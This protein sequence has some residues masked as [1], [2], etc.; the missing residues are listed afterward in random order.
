MSLSHLYAGRV[1]SSSLGTLVTKSHKPTSPSLTV[2][3]VWIGL[4]F[5]FT[6]FHL[7]FFSPLCFSQAFRP[8]MATRLQE[9]FMD[10]LPFLPYIA[11]WESPS[12]ISFSTF[13]CSFFSRYVRLE[14][15][16]FVSSFLCSEY[17]VL[18][19]S[20]SMLFINIT[21]FHAFRKHWW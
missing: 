8:H 7:L 11:F 19:H 18:Y 15:Y 9:L 2:F 1:D 17:P 4:S 5:A 6:S 16:G 14:S 12:F 21:L 20:F 10:F 13:P 3:N